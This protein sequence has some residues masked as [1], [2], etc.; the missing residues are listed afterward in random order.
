M[1]TR[2][3]SRAS[4]EY[5]RALES[6]ERAL[7]LGWRPRIGGYRKGVVDL[8]RSDRTYF[9]WIVKL[10]GELVFSAPPFDEALDFAEA[11]HVLSTP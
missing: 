3:S 9:K 1:S 11:T 10:R 5:N 4:P 6:F 7:L 2:T 8:L